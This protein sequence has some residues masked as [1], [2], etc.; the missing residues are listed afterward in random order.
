MLKKLKTNKKSKKKSGRR[1][2]K[3][4]VELLQ[5]W[6]MKSP[7]F[8]SRISL[9]KNSPAVCTRLRTEGT[10]KIDKVISNQEK[11]SAS[12]T[13]ICFGKWK[14]QDQDEYKKEVVIK[15]SFGDPEYN[16][17]QVERFIYSYLIPLMSQYTPH[18]V[19]FVDLLSCKNDSDLDLNIG[20]SSIY[21]PKEM[22]VNKNVITQ[23]RSVLEDLRREKKFLLKQ[24]ENI[25]KQ[26][27][28]YLVTEKSKGI[29]LK[30]FL[31][32]KAHSLE[33]FRNLLFQIAY[34]LIVFEKMGFMHYD[35]HS[36]NIF[37]EQLL[38]PVRISYKLENN[39]YFTFETTY[40]IRI[41]DF[42]H[43]SKIF[44]PLN[45]KNVTNN[46]LNENEY[47]CKAL[48]ECNKMKKN[49]DW[50]TILS[51]MYIDLEDSPDDNEKKEEIL[52]IAHINLLSVPV[53]GKVG[54]FA[55]RGRA[56]QCVHTS[57]SGNC[58]KC[59]DYDL[60]KNMVSMYDYLKSQNENTYWV[61]KG[62]NGEWDFPKQG[63]LPLYTL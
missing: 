18:L 12:Q 14:K 25:L 43:S 46:A 63:S 45:P 35:L 30:N 4:E 55:W 10:W 53:D 27:V 32:E 44:S 11:N 54:S 36:G 20:G 48:G 5:E 23:N 22:L 41:Y 59:Q 16:T 9:G 51:Y 2:R 47:L 40:T 1:R 58:T 28:F 52:K 34:T 57:D 21:D 42:D 19:Q 33:T 8:I 15:V 17:L 62:G 13:I 3:T 60:G 7:N 61:F 38:N 49:W 26:Y 24:N 31:K 50:F 6:N 37:V 29:P 39:R 56:C